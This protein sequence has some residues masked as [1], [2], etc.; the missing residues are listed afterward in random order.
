MDGRIMQANFIIRQVVKLLRPQFAQGFFLQQKQL[1]GVKSPAMIVTSLCWKT[2][3]KVIPQHC[4][5]L[6]CQSYSKQPRACQSQKTTNN[7]QTN[8]RQS[9]HNLFFFKDDKIQIFPFF[10]LMLNV[11]KKNCLRRN[12]AQHPSKLLI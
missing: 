6:S 1:A 12:L 10:G 8:K 7:K 11:E 9:N 3:A 4:S 5:P 2:M